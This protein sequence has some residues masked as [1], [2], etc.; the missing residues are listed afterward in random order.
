M[1]LGREKQGMLTEFWWEN[2]LEKST[3]KIMK[4]MGGKYAA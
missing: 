4:E 2:V 3:W 1:W